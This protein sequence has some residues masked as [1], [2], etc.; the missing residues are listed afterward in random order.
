M[1]YVR[2]AD[3]REFLFAGDAASS[4][5]NVR[6]VRPRSRYVMVFGGHED[7]R[8]AVFRQTSAMKK[9]MD[10]NPDLTLVPGHDEAAL[11]DLENQGL[12]KRGFSVP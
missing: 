2:Q 6:L 12:L 11:L 7:D 10:A 4:L 5:D 9:L 8:D 1:V 3:G